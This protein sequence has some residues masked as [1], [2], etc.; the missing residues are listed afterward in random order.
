[1]APIT[2]DVFQIDDVYAQGGKVLT[3][4]QFTFEFTDGFN[5]NQLPL[6]LRVGHYWIITK[7]D[8][9]RLW[10]DTRLEVIND[11]GVRYYAHAMDFY[12]IL[13]S[14]HL[15]MEKII[16]KGFIIWERGTRPSIQVISELDLLFTLCCP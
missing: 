6:D 3:Q 9:W 13:E 14:H 12:L 10:K 5:L 16:D 7:G 15:P 2:V 4:R 8:P 11:F 1:M